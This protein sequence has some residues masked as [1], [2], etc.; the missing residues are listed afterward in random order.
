MSRTIGRRDLLRVGAVGI[1]GTAI[2]GNP[3]AVAGVVT[4][5]RTAPLGL[6]AQIERIA[7][8]YGVPAALL[9]AMGYVN[10]RWEMP[11]P[12]V[13][14]Y[15]NGDPHRQGVYGVMALVRNPEADT[16]GTA[17]RLTGL[18]PAELMSDRTANLAGG[19]ALLAWS[20]GGGGPAREADWLPAVSGPGGQ[21]P[22][23]HATAGVG[24][25][26]LYAEEVADALSSGFS[27]H[28]TS[29]EG[30]ALAA[31]SGGR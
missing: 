23:V 14:A 6:T 25:G 20:Q 28:T 26:E 30:L 29:G 16:L 1:A 15:Q 10:T 17:S 3:R 19:A 24:G 27:L 5:A 2:L 7:G 31:R 8:A 4:A 22:T 21:G 18:S 11:P 9:L 12:S 13:S